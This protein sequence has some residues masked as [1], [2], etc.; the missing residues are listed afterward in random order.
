MSSVG[1][2]RKFNS[3][4]TVCVDCEKR[5]PL[6]AAAFRG[7]A[8]MTQLLL[9]YGAKVNLKDSKWL[10]PL[11]WACSIGSEVGAKRFKNVVLLH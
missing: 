2:W 6:H 5:S 9:D 3:F 8:K 1:R 11:H 7:D 10:T 4:V